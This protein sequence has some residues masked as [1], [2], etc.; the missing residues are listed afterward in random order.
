MLANA[1]RNNFPLCSWSN[2][3]PSPVSDASVRKTKGLVT[4]GSLMIGTLHNACFNS[5][6]DSFVSSVQLTLFRLRPTYL[7]SLSLD[8][9]AA[10]Q[11][12]NCYRQT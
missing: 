10:L 5:L 6:N 11:S 2:I 4:F 8:H 1:I 7:V 9:S 12:Y 3:V